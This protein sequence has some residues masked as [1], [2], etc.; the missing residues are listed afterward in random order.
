MSTVFLFPQP[1]LRSFLSRPKLSPLPTQPA[2]SFRFFHML[3]ST[4][5]AVLYTSAQNP[6]W[7]PIALQTEAT[8]S[9]LCATWA[10]AVTEAFTLNQPPSR[11][12]SLS[13]ISFSSRKEPDRCC[14]GALPPFQKLPRPLPRRP[15]LRGPAH[16]Y[17]LVELLHFWR[18]H[19]ETFQVL[20]YILIA[21]YGFQMYQCL[22]NVSVIISEELHNRHLP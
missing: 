9:M 3:Y 18:T 4:E 6:P 15:S 2:H 10:P 7:L 16:P 22:S 13:W 1:F 17:I 20:L 8:P 19:P 21:P 12:L 11:V 14:L 5:Q